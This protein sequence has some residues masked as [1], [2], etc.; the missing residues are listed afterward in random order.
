MTHHFWGEIGTYL[1]QHAKNKTMVKFP[2]GKEIASK[3]DV[4]SRKL[5]RTDTSTND[6][7][8]S[9]LGDELDILLTTF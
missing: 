3:K 9:C 1:G 8:Q 2:R 7:S 4:M 5:S 6:V